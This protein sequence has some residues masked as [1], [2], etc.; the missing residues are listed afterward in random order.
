MVGWVGWT[1]EKGRE[2]RSLF[3]DK[4]KSDL[5]KEWSASEDRLDGGSLHEEM[6]AMEEEEEEEEA[7]KKMETMMMMMLRASKLK[8]VR[9]VG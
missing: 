3:I 8:D 9:A 2:K 7:A 5:K 4:K 6:E 1:E